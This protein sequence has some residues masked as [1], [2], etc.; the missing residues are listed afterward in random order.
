MADEQT[1]TPTLNL[2]L[3]PQGKFA[4]RCI[5]FVDDLACW[6][7]ANQGKKFGR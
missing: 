1:P 7:G 2:N 6:E 3:Y 4:E 5:A